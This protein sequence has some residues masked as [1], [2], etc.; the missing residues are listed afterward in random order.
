MTVG[1]IKAGKDLPEKGKVFAAYTARH[2]RYVIFS[3]RGFF[4]A[5]GAAG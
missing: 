4:G 3:V 2:L 5:G 1:G